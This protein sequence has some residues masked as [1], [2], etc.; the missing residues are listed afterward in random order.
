MNQSL[1]DLPNVEAWFNRTLLK[2]MVT[3]GLGKEDAAFCLPY[4]F[5]WVCFAEIP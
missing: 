1:E 3:C 4:F 5:S 2:E